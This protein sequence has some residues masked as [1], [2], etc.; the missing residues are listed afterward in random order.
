MEMRNAA[1]STK[2]QAPSTKQARNSKHLD[3]TYFRDFRFLEFAGSEPFI[4]D[5]ENL[6]ES[7]SSVLRHAKIIRAKALSYCFLIA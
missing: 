5:H 1:L 3:W 4:V 6:R 2:S 7:T